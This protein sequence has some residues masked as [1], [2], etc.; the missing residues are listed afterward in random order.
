MRFFADGPAIPDVLLE[1]CDAGRVVFL[2]GAGVSVPSGMPDFVSLTK[3]VIEFFAPSIDSEIM[4]AF[5]PWLDKDKPSSGN[6]PLDQI[7]NLLHAEYGNDEVNALVTQ[8]LS[9]PPEQTDLGSKHDL[10]KRVSSSQG[11]QPQVVTTNFDHLF[12]IGTRA[13]NLKIHIPPAFPDIHFGTPIEGI[14]YLHGRL[15]EITA[16]KHPYV[17]SSADFGR[18]YLSEGWATSFIRHL[19]ERYT[20]VLVGYQAED[21]PIKYLLQGLN[22]SSDSRHANL[23]AFDRGNPEDIEVKWRDRGVTAIAYSDH[24]DLWK[25][26]EAWAERSDDP[27]KWRKSVI[28]KCASDPKTLSSHERGQ[29]AHVLRYVQGAKLLATASFYVHPEWLCVLDGN[30]RSAKIKRG[31]GDDA[32]SFEPWAAYGLDDDLKDFSDDDRRRGVINDNLLAQREVDFF[33]SKRAVD[34]IPKRLDYLYIWISKLNSPVAVW[35]AA[36]QFRLHPVLL[37]RIEFQLGYDRTLDIKARNIWRLILE[38]HKDSRI[39][40]QDCSWFDFK[41]RVEIEGWS[42]SIIRE[43]RRISLPYLDL[44]SPVGIADV[45]PP[46][47]SWND[48]NYSEIAQFDVKLL[49]RHAQDI[50]IPDGYLPRVIATLQEH[51]VMASELLEDIGSFY[52]ERFDCYPHRAT[53]GDSDFDESTDMLSWFIHLWD[54]LSEIS[55]TIANAFAVSWPVDDRFFF[56]QFKLYAFNNNKAFEANYVAGELLALDQESFWN[57]DIERELLFLLEDRWNEFSSIY[58]TALADRILNGPE[59][60]SYWSNEEFKQ[61]KTRLAATYAQ[62]LVLKGCQLTPKHTNQLKT[63]I[64]QIPEWEDSW[65]LSV[66]EKWGS[67]GG[68]VR[69]DENPDSIAKLPI[70]E[71]VPTVKAANNR[72]FGELTDKMPFTGLVKLNPRKALLALVLARKNNEFPEYLWDSMIEVLPSEVSPRVRWVF[73]NQILCL[74]NN[75]IVK[76]RYTLGRWI[77]KNINI[78]LEFDESLAW[79]VFD[80]IVEGIT[81]GGEETTRS[82]LGDVRIAG[83]VVQRSRRTYN[84][85]INSPIGNCTRALFNAVPR[86]QQAA[87]SLIPSYIKTRIENLFNILGEGG[88]HAVSISCSNLN[89]LMFVDPE[90]VCERIIP[91]LA[92]MH[93]KS[94]PA[95]NGLIHGRHR[96]SETLSEVLKPILLE[97]ISWID[98]KSWD[99][100]L[101]E[102]VAIWLGLMRIFYQGRPSGISRDEI[103][104]VIRSM[105]EDTR[106]R[107]IFWLSRVGRENEDG[108]ALVRH[109]IDYDW[110]KERRYKTAN[111]VK[112]FIRLL[113]QSGDEFPELY[114]AVKKYLVPLEQDEQVFYIFSHEFAGAEP[115]A[116]KFPD[117]VLDLMD[118]CL[119]KMAT[120]IPFGF[121]DALDLIVESSPEL[122]L[123]KRYFRLID[124]V[125][126]S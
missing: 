26:M 52:F 5:L 31:Y 78:I 124:L 98:G 30:I 89:W 7:F 102:R 114:L 117:G 23:Y 82:A 9:V 22:H 33:R 123:D 29:V 57:S 64:S 8:R 85:A 115:L 47:G 80:R 43:F 99:D 37:K 68:Y 75:I 79:M 10:I 58:Q 116:R 70:D 18:A 122:E 92:L 77:E 15:V 107:F 95:W 113:S 20:V 105:S 13:E 62:Y 32:E 49:E 71:I 73:L 60:Q 34:N 25:T 104:K 39:P 56:H 6:V 53:K 93:S 40:S 96:L 54:R 108:W 27:R 103:C 86:E 121:S 4:K 1:R 50:D 67:Y 11:G 24:P 48:V 63:M 2:C 41:K 35:W 76:L 110:P 72:Q 21:P 36:K 38:H 65:A 17:L 83:H 28:A 16:E 42:G 120:Q 84:H 94:E 125:E 97:L 88:D 3:Y 44:V 109:F 111:T 69:R 59:Q 51:L 87:N 66:V 101:A 126:S 19:L 61:H 46:Q 90:W 112:A 45:R 100:K 74:P 14:T 106:C 55:P 119:P 118:T 91:M 12:E 81:S